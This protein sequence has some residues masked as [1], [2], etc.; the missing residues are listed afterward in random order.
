MIVKT[1]VTGSLSSPRRTFDDFA[2]AIHDAGQESPFETLITEL[3]KDFEESERLEWLSKI[4]TRLRELGIWNDAYPYY[5]IL[6][7]F[8]HPGLAGVFVFRR[9]RSRRQSS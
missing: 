5:T 9:F 2:R 6:S 3:R 4:D 1:G 7:A 8:V